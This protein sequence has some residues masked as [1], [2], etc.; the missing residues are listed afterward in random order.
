MGLHP[1]DCQAPTN[2]T[3][4]FFSSHV[5]NNNLSAISNLIKQTPEDA[6]RS[7]LSSYRRCGGALQ[8]R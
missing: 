7:L 1:H 4:D 6:L 5:N 2:P 8:L 3:S